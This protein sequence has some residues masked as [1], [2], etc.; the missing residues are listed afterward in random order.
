MSP[1]SYFIDWSLLVNWINWLDNSLI[2]ILCYLDLQFYVHGTGRSLQPIKQ[3][4]HS[5]YSFTYYIY[6]LTAGTDN[7]LIW[8]SLGHWT[9][10]CTEIVWERTPFTGWPEEWRFANKCTEIRIKIFWWYQT[11]DTA[12]RGIVMLLVLILMCWFVLLDWHYQYSFLLL[13]FSILILISF[14]RFRRWN[15]SWRKLRRTFCLGWAKLLLT[16]LVY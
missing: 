11:E 12:E 8:G 2:S 5:F 3:T 7:Q 14:N 4:L 10:N 16:D 9:S 15:V 6:Q 1:L 13:W